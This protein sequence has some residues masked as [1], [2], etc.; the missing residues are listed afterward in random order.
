[1]LLMI[2]RARQKVFVFLHALNITVV[3]VVRLHRNQIPHFRLYTIFHP[4]PWSSRLVLSERNVPFWLFR[5]D[6]AP[7]GAGDYLRDHW[8]AVWVDLGLLKSIHSSLV[9][10]D[11]KLKEFDLIP[12]FCYPSFHCLLSSKEK[13]LYHQPH[14]SWLPLHLKVQLLFPM[15]ECYLFLYKQVF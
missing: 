5:R 8:T 6:L 4:N 12:C 14:A 1:M 10:I 9:L 13:L 15:F 11:S 3:E 7:A 2:G